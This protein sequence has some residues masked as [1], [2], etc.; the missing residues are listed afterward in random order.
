MTTE[1]AS[2]L[3]AALRRRQRE[4]KLGEREFAA[5]LGVSAAL[6]NRVANGLRPVN[7]RIV[8]GCVRSYPDL[9][10]AVNLFLRSDLPIDN[11]DVAEG[12]QEEES[13]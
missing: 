10:E 12:L 11:S 9:L 1:Q 8:R 7:L 13:A 6:W 5:T 4:L 2:D 3:I